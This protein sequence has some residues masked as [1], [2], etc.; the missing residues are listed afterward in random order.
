MLSS[1]RCRSISGGRDSTCAGRWQGK[2]RYA[3]A[4]QVLEVENAR[5]VQVLKDEN[6]QLTERLQSVEHGPT[7]TPR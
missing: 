6:A 4:V 2:Q 5:A 3:R 1:M 7:L